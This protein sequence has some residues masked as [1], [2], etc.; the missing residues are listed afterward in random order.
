MAGIPVSLAKLGLPGNRVPS[1]KGLRLRAVEN[2]GTDAEEGD[3]PLADQ[4]TNE[5]ALRRE[6]AG[7]GGHNAP[8]SNVSMSTLSNLSGGSP[9]NV[10]QGVDCPNIGGSS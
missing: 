2:W 5:A 10:D 6:K 4:S 8:G 3:K 7:Q 1:F 9:P